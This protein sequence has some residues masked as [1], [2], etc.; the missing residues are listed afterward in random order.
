[1]PRL[2]SPDPKRAV[3]LRIHSSV[4]EAMGEGWRAKMEALIEG[5]EVK[6]APEAKPS[7]SARKAPASTPAAVGLPL[8][9]PQSVYG[10]RLKKR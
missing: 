9:R 7:R 10:S 3:T 6:L 5:G 1:M 8:G 2:K 4:I